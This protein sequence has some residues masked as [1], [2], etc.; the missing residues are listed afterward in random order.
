MLWAHSTT[1]G[2]IRATRC[3][4]G[5]RKPT[6]V[7]ETD[8]RKEIT[9]REEKLSQRNERYD[10]FNVP[11][12]RTLWERYRSRVANAM[13]SSRVVNAMRTSLFQSGERYEKFTVP[14]WRTYEQFQSGER[15]DCSRVAN[16]M[17]NLPFQSGERY[18]NFTVPE[19]PTL[20]ELCR[21]IMPLHNGESYENFTVPEWRT[22]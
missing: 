4:K 12:W 13:N 14:E 2:Y 3:A 10:N 8:N 20:W 19:W 18:E 6:R 7:Q 9:G 17:R 15:Y 1:Y 11:E 16:A 22:L 5:C 21:S